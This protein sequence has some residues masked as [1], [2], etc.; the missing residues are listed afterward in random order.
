MVRLI[1]ADS[2]VTYLWNPITRR[3]LKVEAILYPKRR[4]ELNLH[5]KK[6]QKTFTFVNAVKASQRTV[7]SDLT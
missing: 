2:S 4:F 1:E 5:S 3:S 6:S 7:F